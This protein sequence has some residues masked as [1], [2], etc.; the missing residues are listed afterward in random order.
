[1]CLVTGAYGDDDKEDDCVARA[2]FGCGHVVSDVADDLLTHSTED[3]ACKPGIGENAGGSG[4]R[5]SG[6][7][8]IK[9]LDQ[10]SEMVNW[11]HGSA[12]ANSNVAVSL[13][14]FTE[15]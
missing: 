7:Q 11:R 4:C 12:H 15:K 8:I 3:V 13:L 6:I 5:A 9:P 2:A 10:S 1:M 14:I